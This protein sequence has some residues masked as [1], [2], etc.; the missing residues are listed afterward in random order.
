M[1][2]IVESEGEP[3]RPTAE[4]PEAEG[5]VDGGQA[6]ELDAAAFLTAAPAAIDEGPPPRN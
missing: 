1:R 4:E 6:P 2:V 5:A 3:E